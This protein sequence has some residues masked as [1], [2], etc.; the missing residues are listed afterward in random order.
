VA[1]LR[2]SVPIWFGEM[3]GWAG[4]GFWAETTPLA[5]YPFSHFFLLFFSNFLNSDLFKTS[6]NLFKSF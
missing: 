2:C 4:F 6:E 5:F 3:A 1:A